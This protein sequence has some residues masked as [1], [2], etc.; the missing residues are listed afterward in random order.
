MA[1][2]QQTA[3]HEQTETPDQPTDS[4]PVT[5]I[6]DA[7]LLPLTVEELDRAL[8]L[9]WP[10]SDA[11]RMAAEIAAAVR[12]ADEGARAAANARARGSTNPAEVNPPSWMVSPELFAI[13][14]CDPECSARIDEAMERSRAES[15]ERRLRVLMALRRLPSDAEPPADILRQVRQER[16]RSRASWTRRKRAMAD[17]LGVPRPDGS[18]APS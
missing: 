1:T 12:E 2:G 10:E 9:A 15:S 14:W 16:G 7:E 11:K 6:L 3:N 18:S 17:R 8:R 4:L 5:G 13:L